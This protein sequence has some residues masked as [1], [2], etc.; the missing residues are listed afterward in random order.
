I[1]VG[2]SG[3]NVIKE[4]GRIVVVTVETGSESK[5]GIIGQPYGLGAIAHTTDHR[6]RQKH[7]FEKQGMISRRFSKS[8]RDEVAVRQF[9]FSHPL[10]TGQYARSLLG[11]LFAVALVVFQRAA[12][13]NRTEPVFL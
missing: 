11:K 5:A 4:V 13:G 3:L 9:T 12:G 7:L 6:D 1:H 10:T 8:R 2:D